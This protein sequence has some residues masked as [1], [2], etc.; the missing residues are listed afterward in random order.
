MSK[1]RLVLLLPFYVPALALA[2]V[3][4]L[5]G[6]RSWHVCLSLREHSVDDPDWGINVAIEGKK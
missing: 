2:V 5:I 3:A 4:G 1:L 6:G